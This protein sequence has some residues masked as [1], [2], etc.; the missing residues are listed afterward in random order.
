MMN[1][2]DVG[3]GAETQAWH[4]LERLGY[5]LLARNVHVRFAE[6]DLVVRQGHT[7]AFVEVKSTRAQHGD[8]ALA[9][10]GHIKRQRIARAAALWLGW[11]RSKLPFMRE[12]R[13]DII[14]V[15]AR[16][17]EHREAAFQAD[18]AYW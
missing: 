12:V 16:G 13:F 14:C 18:R 17:I 6:L 5:E 15:T 11:N 2:R 1:K 9:K 10:V 4:Y 3:S 8:M 7:V